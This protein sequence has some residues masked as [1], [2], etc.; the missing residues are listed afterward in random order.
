MDLG[1]QASGLLAGYK[2]EVTERSNGQTSSE[3]DSTGLVLEKLYM[4]HKG[5]RNNNQGAKVYATDFE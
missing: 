1:L 4:T 3:I 2:F 5:L